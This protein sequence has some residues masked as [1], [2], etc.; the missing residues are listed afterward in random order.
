[1]NFSDVPRR[2][3]AENM[4]PMINVVF[5]LLIFF[6]ISAQ[7]APP[8]PFAV[9]PPVAGNEDE[10][11]ADLTLYLSAGGEIGYRDTV[12]EDALGALEAARAEI[13]GEACD[14][15]MPLIL[16]AD[17]AVSAAE[18]AALLPELGARG[19]AQVLLVT[20]LP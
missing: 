2:P 12:G 17:A 20:A 19:F 15:G 14:A 1:M 10:G 8:E 13:C 11:E 18:V 3:Q 4:L 9:E 7:L 5:L 6:L 16:R